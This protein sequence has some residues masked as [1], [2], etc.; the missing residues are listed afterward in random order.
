MVMRLDKL[1][2]NYGMGTRKEVKA[3][4]RKGYVTVNGEVI[5]KDDYKVDYEKDIIIFDGQL[6]ALCIY[7]A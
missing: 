5:K 7:N 4:I 6:S 2:A 1:L 3:F